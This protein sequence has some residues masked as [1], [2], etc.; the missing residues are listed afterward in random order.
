MYT[1]MFN[2]E[3]HWLI[4]WLIDWLACSVFLCYLYSM[5]PEGGAN[6]RSPC[7]LNH[8]SCTTRVLI[9]SLP[10][11]PPSLCL[12]RSPVDFT[13]LITWN[14]IIIIQLVSRYWPP[15]SALPFWYISTLN[16]RLAR[17]RFIPQEGE[18]KRSWL[19]SQLKLNKVFF[20][21]L[22]DSG[23][24]VDMEGLMNHFLNIAY[25]VSPWS[26]QTRIMCRMWRFITPIYSGTST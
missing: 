15:E 18:L 12:Y 20:I 23:M 22:N 16:R 25:R 1:H 19:A 11:C 14:I 2:G 4:D 17:R 21:K 7:I 26:T 13:H 10:F 6:M 3:R 9:W 5:L 8:T 24:P